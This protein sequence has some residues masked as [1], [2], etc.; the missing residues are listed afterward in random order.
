MQR[1]EGQVGSAMPRRQQARH[2]LKPGSF[3]RRSSVQMQD[4]RQKWLHAYKLPCSRK[5]ILSKLRDVQ[6]LFSSTP[7]LQVYLHK[8]YIP[9]AP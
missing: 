1:L 4:A 9:Q 7:G 6:D 8:R 3:Q 2:E 5:R